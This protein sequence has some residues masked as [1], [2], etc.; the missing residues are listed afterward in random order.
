VDGSSG[1]AVVD[2]T[3]LPCDHQSWELL[4]DGNM[5]VAHN[6]DGEDTLGL[7]VVTLVSSSPVLERAATSTGTAG[8]VGGA[9]PKRAVVVRGTDHLTAGITDH[10]PW[11][12]AFW[13]Q[14]ALVSPFLLLF[15]SETVPAH[16]IPVWEAAVPADIITLVVAIERTS[17]NNGLEQLCCR[18]KTQAQHWR[19]SQRAGE[20]EE[21]DRA[22]LVGV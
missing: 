10:G 3:P 14:F 2:Q 8:T 20:D 19:C 17:Q 1:S 9:P 7:A 18:G 15:C 16:A 13:P 11:R 4:D 12:S 22:Q 21:V 6:C 5:Y